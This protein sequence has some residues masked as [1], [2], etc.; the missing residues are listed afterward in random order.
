MF[1]SIWNPRSNFDA[2]FECLTSLI[3]LRFFL[4][5]SD[6]CFDFSL[7]NTHNYP[8]RPPSRRRPSW[9][10]LRLE[11]GL[12]IFLSLSLGPQ[13]IPVI[14]LEFLAVW[15]I[16]EKFTNSGA[17]CRF[18]RRLLLL[19]R[20]PKIVSLSSDVLFRWIQILWFAFDVL[21]HI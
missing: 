3:F 18:R 21:K 13:G 12:D 10:S 20:L 7:H 16:L 6:F 2:S 4:H 8:P 11:F 1:A 17:V 19:L 15:R 9:A 5:R 14:F